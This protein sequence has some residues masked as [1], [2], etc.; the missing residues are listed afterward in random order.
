M[1]NTYCVENNNT[2]QPVVEQQAPQTAPAQSLGQMPPSSTPKP[3]F[4][5]ATIISIIIFLL[6]AGSAAGFY[7]FKPQIMSLVSR[8]TPTPIAV[9]PSVTP[10]PTQVA[11][12]SSSLK[13]Y[14]ESTDTPGQMRY[15]SPQLGISFLYMLKMDNYTTAITED[16]SKI[17]VYLKELITD[18]KKDNFKGGQ[19]IEVFAKDKSQTLTDAI[20][21]KFLTNYSEKDCFVTSSLS[22]IKTSPYPASY[23]LAVIS[24]PK[25]TGDTADPWWTNA[26]K[27]PKDYSETNGISYFMMD[28][29]YPGKFAFLSIGQYAINGTP[30]QS[31][32]N[33]VEFLP[34]ATPSAVPTSVVCNSDADCPTGSTC[35]AQGPLIANQ[36]VKKTCSQPGTANPL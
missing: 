2:N 34:E 10:S 20:R 4:S 27:C 24:Y 31:W 11:T 26:D 16:G 15:V 1:P 13:S 29:N 36:P 23:Q 3:K 19:W 21:Q 18:G 12:S 6:V 28:K 14:A 32:Q 5:L 25:P 17:Y 22:Q 7:V 35:V 30:T 8:P 33:T 9:E